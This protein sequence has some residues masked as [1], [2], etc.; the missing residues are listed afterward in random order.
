MVMFGLGRQA[1]FEQALDDLV[2]AY[3]AG[4][5]GLAYWT[6][7]TH[8]YADDRDA[9]F[10]WLERAARDGALDM[11]PNKHF[12]APYRDDPRWADL[13]ARRETLPADLQA[14]PFSVPSLN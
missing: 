8:A 2:T 14:I 1:E 13:M 7:Y 12:L 4:D 10:E 6:A 11:A 3:E 5:P 9:T